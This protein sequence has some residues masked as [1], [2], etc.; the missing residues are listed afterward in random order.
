MRQEKS[1][2]VEGV[3]C[4]RQGHDARTFEQ[5]R[6]EHSGIYRALGR[7]VAVQGT[8]AGEGSRDSL[9]SAHS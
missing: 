3:S 1:S 4:R 2:M 9:T 7:A 5:G 6:R 8:L